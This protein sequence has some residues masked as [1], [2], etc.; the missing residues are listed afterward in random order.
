L[1]LIA[2]LISSINVHATFSTTPSFLCFGGV[3]LPHISKQVILHI[4]FLYRKKKRKKSDTI[5]CWKCISF[6]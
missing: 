5:Y 4:Y 3:F 2:L 6:L 1:A